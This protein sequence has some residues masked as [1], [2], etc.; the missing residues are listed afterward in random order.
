MN[1]PSLLRTA[2]ILIVSL[3]LP[4]MVYGQSTALSL[5]CRSRHETEAGSG[6]WHSVVKPV[7]WKSSETAIV[8]CDMWDKHW[9]PNATA[10]VAE[11][12]PRMNVVLKEARRRGVLIIHCPSDTMDYY[13][14][15]PQR[16]LARSAPVVETK[17]PLE[18]WCHLD[19]EREGP[20]LPIDDSD[21]G[22]DCE[23]PVKSY[24]AWSRQ[25]PAIE[26]ADQDAITDSAEAWYLM[27]Q[28]GITNV[29]VMGV[30]TNM[31]VL[32]RPFSIRQMVNQGQNVVLMRDMTDTMYNP[33]QAPFVS[34]FT[35]NDLV[36]EHIEQYWCPSVTSADIT[37]EEP[38][39]FSGDKRPHLVI[40][41]SEPEYKTEISLP[42]FAREHLGKDF[43]VSIVY[44]DAKVAD[45]LPGIEVIQSA[46]LLFLSVRRRTPPAEQ[47]QVIRD[48]IAAGKPVM[49]IRTANHAFCLRNKPA[50][51]GLAD[52]P[53]FD[54]DVIGGSY[55]NHWGN[56][57]KTVVSVSSRDVAMHPILKGLA[58]EQFIGHGSLYKVAPLQPT[59]TA[60]LSGAIPEAPPE[61]IAFVNQRSDG[62]LT[63]YTSLGHIEDFE[64]PEF[65]QLLLNAARWLV[66]ESAEKN[67]TNAK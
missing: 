33:A 10:R 57:P 16:E 62:G 9:C 20:K 14:D 8:V 41:T 53:E 5:N 36:T 24:R 28:R 12:A 37:G 49:G 3:L 40:V 61:P 55:T 35:G 46:D 25:H 47:L 13:K 4:A 11:M 30:H 43:R 29:I 38:F 64:Q 15:Y 27:K 34:H 31:C 59:A 65:N 6:R 26:I 60:L 48:Y 1:A 32:G 66:K 52:W 45:S 7:E 50:P 18:R 58:P 56:G 42:K 39:R 44:G 19:S 51:E 22:C 17:I 67:S 63:F 23:G 54:R 21:G 2:S